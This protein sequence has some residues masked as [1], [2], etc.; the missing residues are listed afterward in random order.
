M[1]FRKVAVDDLP[2]TPNPTRAKREVDES[3][4][5]SAFGFNVY[6]AAPGEALPWGYHRHPD[7]EE[8]FYVVAGELAV[9]TPDG[10]L[11]VA[12][13]EALFVPPD[14]PNLARATGDEPARVVAVGAPK[15]SD[16]AVIEEDCPA[17][18]ETTDRDYEVADD[19]DTYVLRCAGCGAETDRF[20][21]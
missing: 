14:H 3:V 19:G 17:C 13:G 20:S 2:N 8:L 16:G 10:E 11:S 6:E 18:G 21:A 15:T 12:A 7:H 5:A 4:G 9:E 1:E